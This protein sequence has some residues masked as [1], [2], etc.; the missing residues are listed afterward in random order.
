V[1]IYLIWVGFEPQEFLQ[2]A[3]VILLLGVIAS[4]HP[5]SKKLNQ[6]TKVAVLSNDPLRS[7]LPYWGYPVNQILTGEIES[8]MKYLVESVKK[9]ISKGNG[10]AVQRAESWRGPY[11]KRK[12]AWK[13]K[14]LTRKEQKP[15]DKRWVT[16]ELA[17][18][19]PPDALVV[20]ET[21]TH[22]LSIHRYLDML[23]PGSFFAGC[24]GGLGTGTGTALGVKAAFPSG[25]FSVSSATARSIMIPDWRPW[26]FARSTSCRSC[27]C[28][29]T[30]MAITRKSPAC[31]GSSQMDLP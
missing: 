1:R 9:R 6:G 30:I 12:A 31:P 3:D 4:W 5:A 8:S 19:I 28:S 15:L 25:L 20:E 13:D 11:E 27:S 10:D 7:D 18:V 22:R 29:T 21:I 14:A 24:I 2:E 16:Y 26:E 17:Q 23:K